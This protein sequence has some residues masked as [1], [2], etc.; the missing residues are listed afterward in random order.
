MNYATHQKNYSSIH[1]IVARFFAVD[2]KAQNSYSMFFLSLFISLPPVKEPPSDCCHERQHFFNNLMSKNGG[3]EEIPRV[4]K[5]EF[6]TI[7]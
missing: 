2:Y 4:M 6:A 5:K 1:H 7:K 3:R